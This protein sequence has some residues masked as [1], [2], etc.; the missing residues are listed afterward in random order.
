MNKI[1]GRIYCVTNTITGKQYVGQTVRTL[2]LRWRSHVHGGSPALHESIKFYGRAAFSIREIA[3]AESADELNRLEVKWIAKLGTLVPGGY[4]L[5]HGGQPLVGWAPE[6]NQR[7][8]ESVRRLWA[9]P[10]VRSKQTAAI[11]A[12]FARDD[13]KAKVAAFKTRRVAI[14]AM[15]KG[16]KHSEAS[17][18]ARSLRM[19]GK[20]RGPYKRHAT[21]EQLKIRGAA[22]AAARARNKQA[23]K[24]AS[25]PGQ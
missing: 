10:E 22:V 21:N 7:R 2:A 20:K 19:N 9:D 15:S 3:V 16:R 5:Q 8:A 13:V 17:R 14:G 11:A 24:T 6:V 4:N 12:A 18:L 1:H 25:L 23:K